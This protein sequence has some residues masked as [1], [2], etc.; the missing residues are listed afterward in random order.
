A[1]HD[2]N[3]LLSV[4]IGGTD[5]ALSRLP[6]ED[7]VRSE[8]TSV[9]EASRRATGLTQ[10]MLTFSRKS[11]SPAGVVIDINEIIRGMMPIVSR[12]VGKKI[13]LVLE[14]TD[15]PSTIKSDP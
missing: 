9:L 3:N 13:Q 1:A 15:R 10:Q 6:A 12:I 11:A 5:F 7:P 14:L 2:F 4:I 8:L